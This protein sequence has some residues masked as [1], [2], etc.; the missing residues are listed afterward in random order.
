MKTLFSFGSSFT[1]TCFIIA[2]V[3]TPTGSLQARQAVSESDWIELEFRSQE[4]LTWLRIYFSEGE[5]YD[6][7]LADSTADPDGDGY[8]NQFEFLAK[9]DPTDR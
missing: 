9:L 2:V 5:L 7:H 8:S 4:F 3:I 6:I 1:L